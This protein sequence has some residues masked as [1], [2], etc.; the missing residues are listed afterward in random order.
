MEAPPNLAEA[1]VYPT[2]ED[3]FERGLVVLAMG[4][5]YWLLQSDAGGFHLW[6]ESEHLPEVQS[7]LAQYESE[8]SKFDFEKSTYDGWSAL[9]QRAGEATSA[10]TPTASATPL[11]WTLALIWAAATIKVFALQAQYRS[12]TPWGEVDAQAIFHRH[13]YWRPFTALF[14]HAD[15]GHLISNLGA[16]FFVFATVSGLVGRIRGWTLLFAT[17]Y[18]ANLT[19]AAAN[20]GNDYRSLGASTAIFAGLGLLTGR[21]VRLASSPS[22]LVRL[23]QAC[24]GQGT[25]RSTLSKSVLLPLAAGVVLLALYGSGDAQTD[26]LA[27]VCGF[28]WGLAA[29]F[30]LCRNPVL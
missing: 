5:P 29:G 4:L 17:S 13:E 15:F 10:A 30:V 9:S 16:G 1:A 27:H 14:L 2:A 20:R 3:G 19:V 25:T 21:A 28:C 8:K 11:D 12:L 24:A 18:L 6:V 22:A 23:R 7:E 26:V